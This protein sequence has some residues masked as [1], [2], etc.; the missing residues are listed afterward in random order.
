[1][2][3]I[4]IPLLIAA[5]TIWAA[6]QTPEEMRREI[7]AEFLRMKEQ[8][9]SPKPAADKVAEQVQQSR[10]LKS[11]KIERSALSDYSR[12]GYPK[13]YAQWGDHGV[14]RIIEHERKAALL[15]AS[16]PK[17]DRVEVVGL[18]SESKPP[19]QIISFVD[20][21]NRQRFVVGA[22]DLERGN[23]IS[24]A[25]RNTIGNG[26]A[27]VL[28][29]EETRKQLKYPSSADFGIF[30]NSTQRV[31]STGAILVQADFKAM[32]GLGNMIPQR[33]QCVINADG[34]VRVTVTAR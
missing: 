33:A 22:A 25:E 6:E 17:C 24:Q 28:C 32:N 27:V 9:P 12:N 15:V 4:V 31:P 16:N 11:P 21:R 20:C 1:M 19:N 5:T 10:D 18:S 7:E 30:S 26:E 34:S 23:T 14:A 13:T 3:V 29:H 8:D 2:K